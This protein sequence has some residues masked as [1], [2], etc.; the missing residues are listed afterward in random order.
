MT[1]SFSR[2]LPDNAAGRVRDWP[3]ADPQ[4]VICAV[5]AWGNADAAGRLA[6]LKDISSLLFLHNN[7]AKI[8]TCLGSYTQTGTDPTS[9]ISPPTTMLTANLGD[10][11]RSTSPCELDIRQILDA[12]VF[13]YF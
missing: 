11:C 6:L 4:K 3:N 12:D 7:R 2:P 9:S 8:L 10:S 13:V 1:N 5:Q